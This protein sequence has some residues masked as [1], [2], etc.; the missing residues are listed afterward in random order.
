MFSRDADV[1]ASYAHAVLI[2]G[3][4]VFGMAIGALAQLILRQ[5]RGRDVDWAQALIAGLVGSFVGG[6][7]ISL[8]AGDGLDFRPSG[9]IGSL[10]GAIIVS[11]IWGWWRERQTA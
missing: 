9:I 3:L 8:L 10:V 6:L 5:A 2:I 11:A 1:E 7:L 4:L